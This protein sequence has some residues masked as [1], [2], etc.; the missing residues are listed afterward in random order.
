MIFTFISR[1]RSLIHLFCKF[2][3]YILQ[4]SQDDSGTRTHIAVEEQEEKE[5]KGTI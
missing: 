4:D 2:D 1:F 3:Q 5:Y